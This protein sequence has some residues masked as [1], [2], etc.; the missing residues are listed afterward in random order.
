MLCR[1]GTAISLKFSRLKS[2]SAQLCGYA[3][4]FLSSPTV[5]F[6]SAH[7][8]HVQYLLTSVSES[9]AFKEIQGCSGQTHSCP[10]MSR[11]TTVK[12]GDR[13]RRLRTASPA[14]A[15]TLWCSCSS[16]A[17][18]DVRRP[19]PPLNRDPP[20]AITQLI[21]IDR[22]CFVEYRL[23]SPSSVFISEMVPSYAFTCPA[24]SAIRRDFMCEIERRSWSAWASSTCQSAAILQCSLYRIA[25]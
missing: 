14:C 19:L 23:H 11:A 4:F 20:E 22:G 9:T 24:G 6:S 18:T 13:C 8:M 16:N 5:N 2:C 1:S 12:A 7:K 17:R 21:A 25:Q 15:S 3:L 10:R